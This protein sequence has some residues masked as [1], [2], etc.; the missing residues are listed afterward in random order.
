MVKYNGTIPK[1]VF[2]YYVENDITK[3]SP[4]NSMG[5]ISD[6]NEKAKSKYIFVYS[7]FIKTIYLII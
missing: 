7:F 2:D 4:A 1:D 5:L 3:I 6:V